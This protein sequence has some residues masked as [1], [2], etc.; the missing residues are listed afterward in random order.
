MT[1][2]EH[3]TRELELAGVEED[4]RPSIIAAVEAFA[5][6]GHSGGSASVVVPMLH[7]LLQFKNLSPLTSRWDEWN[8]VAEMAGFVVWQNNR[9]SE[10][11][12]YDHGHTYYLL[13]E[14]R[15]W[16]P[17]RIRRW[18]RIRNWIR[19]VFP[20]HTTADAGGLVGVAE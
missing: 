5:S 13:S 20:L 10:A 11:F 12:S 4:V 2:V 9:C 7:D 8:D 16:I 1:L 17:F 6:Y 14:E 18:M 3:A 15:R 19:P